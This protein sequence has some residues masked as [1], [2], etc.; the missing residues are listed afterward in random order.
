[1][2]R[3]DRGLMTYSKTCLSA[4]VGALLLFGCSTRAPHYATPDTGREIDIVVRHFDLSV[5]RNGY[6]GPTDFGSLLAENIAGALQERGVAAVVLPRDVPLPSGVPFEFDGEVERIADGSLFVRI[7]L[8]PLAGKACFSARGWVTDVET[9]QSLSRNYDA[10][11]ACS[12]RLM[13]SEKILRHA[14]SAVARK[15]ADRYLQARQVRQPRSI[16]R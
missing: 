4:F 10:V 11:R 15:L 2:Q 12:N 6:R 3:S 5:A 13:G 14:C 7:L 8:S 1:M 9:E 16:R